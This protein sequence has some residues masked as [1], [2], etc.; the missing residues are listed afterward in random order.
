[1]YVKNGLQ[2]RTKEKV[3]EAVFTCTGGAAL[4]FAEYSFVAVQQGAGLQE[5][6]DLPLTT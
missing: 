1:M 2:V 6:V 3:N 5:A 4:A